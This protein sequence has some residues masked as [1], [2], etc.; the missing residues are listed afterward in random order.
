M[1]DQTSDETLRRILST[2]RVIA[3]AGIV[4]DTSKPSN[5]VAQ[6]LAD[7]GYRVIPVNAARAGEMALGQAILASFA[8]IPADVR[9]DMVDIFRRSEQVPPEVEEA[10][11]HLPHLRTIWMQVG[12]ANAEAAALARARGLTVVQDRCPKVE[13]PRLFGMQKL[14][15]YATDPMV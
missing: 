15:E 14:G 8:D 2:T 1:A 12:I 5:Y 3:V 11:E 4:P 13:L 7:R 6:F 10:L 9:V